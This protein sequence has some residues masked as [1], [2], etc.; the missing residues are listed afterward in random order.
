M[1]FVAKIFSDFHPNNLINIFLQHVYLIFDIFGL[2][3]HRRVFSL[4]VELRSINKNAPIYV[5]DRKAVY[6]RKM[7]ALKSPVLHVKNT[8]REN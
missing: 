2:I 7:F 5:K 4:T 3:R 1:K 6:E 8:V